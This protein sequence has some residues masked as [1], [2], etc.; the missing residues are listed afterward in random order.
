MGV[1]PKGAGL[2]KSQI[3]C[4]FFLMTFSLA[5]IVTYLLTFSCD[6]ITGH[7]LTTS[8]HT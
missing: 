5:K 1:P 6:L 2:S 3:N 7:H 8:S 4:D